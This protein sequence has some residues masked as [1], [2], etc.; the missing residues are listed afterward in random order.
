MR[1][2][3]ETD[4]IAVALRVGAAI[5]SV[6][7]SYF[8][9]GSIASSLQGEPRSTNDIDIVVEMPLGR[10]QAFRDALGADFEVDLDPLRDA[11]MHGRST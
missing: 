4:A 10:L 9:G 5:E 7:G 2:D 8:V 6:G 3:S 11:L 1:A